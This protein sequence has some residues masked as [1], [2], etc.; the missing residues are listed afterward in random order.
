MADEFYRDERPKDP[1]GGG[2]PG[3]P[4][5]GGAGGGG[6]GGGG[7]GGST[8]GWGWTW[9]WG[10]GGGGGPGPEEPEEPEPGDQEEPLKISI[11]LLK[12]S[13][14][15][16]LLTDFSKR[17][18]TGSLDCSI[19]PAMVAYISGDEK[20]EH[21]DCVL[22]RITDFMRK[23]SLEYPVKS[24][25]EHASRPDIVGRFSWSRKGT[26]RV[27]AKW[28]AGHYS[29]AAVHN[30]KFIIYGVSTGYLTLPLTSWSDI[31]VITITDD[32]QVFV[33]KIKGRFNGNSPYVETE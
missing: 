1:T 21:T 33:N 22:I 30:V 14:Y 13:R 4:S 15:G 11:P 32:Y 18:L 6:W 29:H 24:E 10:G 25:P 31:A 23:F 27:Q 20:R 3:G 26:F 8:G 2:D 17:L 19:V 7:G 9:G 12:I 28:Q 16:L 5:G